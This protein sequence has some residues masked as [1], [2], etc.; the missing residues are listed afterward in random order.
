MNVPGF[1]ASLRVFPLGCRY[2]LDQKMEA[3][4]IP[5][6]APPTQ[7]AQGRIS[8]LVALAKLYPVLD[9]SWYRKFDR[10]VL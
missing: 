4:T 5:R 10:T 3:Y 9:I 8:E 6:H 1:Q 2:C 7:T